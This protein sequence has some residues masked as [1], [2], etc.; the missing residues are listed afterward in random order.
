MKWSFD[1]L[2]A[3][4]CVEENRL[5]FGKKIE[6][7]LIKKLNFFLD[8]LKLFFSNEFG[9]IFCCFLIILLSLFKRSMIDIGQDSGLYLEITQKILEG[10][11]YYNDFFEY[12]F[13]I[14]FLLLIIP[15]GISKSLGL[16]P[17]II[18]DYFI[19]LLAIFSLIWAYRILKN[20]QKIQSQ[21]EL[22]LLI[23]CFT[24]GFFIRGKTLF[25]NEFLTKTSFLI[26]F[27]FPFFSYYVYGVE[28]L[29]KIQKIYLGIISGLI[30]SL[31]PNF[32]I[33]VFFF[34]IYRVY[35]SRNI[36]SFLAIHN[37]ICALLISFYVIIIF[38]FFPSFVENF[39]YMMSIYYDYKINYRID[40]FS[41][42]Y[43]L[44]F[45]KIQINYLMYFMLF[46]VYIK[47]GQKNEL[48]NYLM[49]LMLAIIF[50]VFSEN[51]YIDQEI[52]FPALALS[53]II[54]NFV[55]FLKQNK[56][57]ILRYWFLFF[58]L[59]IFCFMASETFSLISSMIYYLGL[60]IFL[61]LVFFRPFIDSKSYLYAK[62]FLMFSIIFLVFLRFNFFKLFDFSFVIFLIIISLI[63]LNLC[64]Q[65]YQVNKKFFHPIV[66][67]V[68][69]TTIGFV[70]EYFRAIFNNYSPNEA[71][72]ALQSPNHQNKVL[73]EIAK[74]NIKTN[75][76]LI[77]FGDAIENSYPFR[78]YAKLRNDS[79]FS[80]YDVLANSL[81]YPIINYQNEIYNNKVLE[82][83]YQQIINPKNN[84]IIFYNYRD[85]TISN[86]EFV[87]RNSREIKEYFLENFEFSTQHFSV[88]EDKSFTPNY[89]QEFLNNHEFDVVKGID[90]TQPKIMKNNIFEA[91]VRK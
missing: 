11:K 66:F 80:Q 91:Y 21:L 88:K 57:S 26:I 47:N 13:P 81:K 83:L 7:Y 5:F 56:I 35:Q 62:I 48:S 38:I 39:S 59:M 49:L 15:V 86:F 33:L 3:I 52:I 6:K 25:F 2:M 79:E 77:I 73:F 69:L 70:G 31:K 1:A 54:I 76:N 41:D 82:S 90:L 63:N 40:D 84:A 85:C 32:I 65:K 44:I 22:N 29:K 50:I 19:N 68:F 45:N 16:S 27:F 58:V 30:I 24:A 28:K 75:D 51:F 89:T 55:N 67:L 36:M 17:I 12:N 87:M 74:S 43:L 61:Y 71:H 9:G 34:E 72:L 60:P 37:L 10:K 64:W 78:N 14:S 4:I 20:S 53:F 42:K 18:S 46:F 23:I 8:Y